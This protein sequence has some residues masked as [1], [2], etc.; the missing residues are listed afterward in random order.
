MGVATVLVKNQVKA[1]QKATLRFSQ[2]MGKLSAIASS[3]QG[4]RLGLWAIIGLSII[5]WV[6]TTTYGKWHSGMWYFESASEVRRLSDENN[7][8]DNELNVVRQKIGWRNETLKVY[9]GILEDRPILLEKSKTGNPFRESFEFEEWSNP[10]LMVQLM[11]KND[12][13]KCLAWVM[14]QPNWEVCLSPVCVDLVLNR[15]GPRKPISEMTYGEKR[16]YFR[17]RDRQ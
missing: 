7:R 6:A 15:A 13:Q 3:L 2:L 11:F 12:A 14:Q 4:V 1:E 16:K 10:D 5:Q 17:G 9:K 8:L